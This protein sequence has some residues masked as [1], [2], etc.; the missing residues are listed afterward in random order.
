MFILGSRLKQQA[1]TLV[2]LVVGIVVMAIALSILST[3]F[4]SS[5][6]RSVEP[7]LM[8]R[9]AEF[10]QALMDEIIGKKFDETTP[11]GGVPACAVPC[12]LAANLGP[13]GAEIRANYNDVDDYNHYC[14]ID[15]VAPYFQLEDTFGNVPEG[16]EN[17]QMSICVGYDG[18]YNGSMNEGGADDQ[19][20]KLIIIDIYVPQTGG[21]SSAVS[22][23]AY[24]G[25]Y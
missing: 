12:T 22:F 7:L 11:D 19:N 4:F 3:V 13:D 9:G 20:A 21:L 15:N 16:F 2:E 6:G 18:D 8:V 5:A 14:D 23:R 1:F 25:N 24:K 17:F 10:G